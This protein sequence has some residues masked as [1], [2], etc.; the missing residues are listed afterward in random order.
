MQFENQII[1][2]LIFLLH[3]DSIVI[4]SFF[5]FLNRFDFPLYSLIFHILLS[6]SMIYL[7]YIYSICYFIQ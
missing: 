1:I 2:T 7:T 5:L 4:R 3:V 6:H